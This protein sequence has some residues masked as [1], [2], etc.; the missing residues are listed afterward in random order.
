M[1]VHK[2]THKPGWF[3]S[4]YSDHGNA[5]VEVR[6]KGENVL[7]R[8]SKYQDPEE[9][10]PISSR[11]RPPR[12]RR[13]AVPP[14]RL[15][16]SSATNSRLVRNGDQ[17][18]H[19]RGRIRGQQPCLRLRASADADADCHRIPGTDQGFST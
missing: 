3:K 12:A 13:L 6:F 8:D 5:C 11:S 1:C 4:S 19:R 2:P 17:R 9:V 18:Q 14:S 7:M 10:R 16:Q 15:R